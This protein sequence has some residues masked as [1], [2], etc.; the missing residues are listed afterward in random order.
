[1][2][3]PEYSPRMLRLFIEGRIVCAM[4]IDGLSRK[5]ARQAALRRIGKAAGLPARH[6]EIAH[7][8]SMFGAKNRTRVWAA[9]GIHP[10]DHGI[11]LTD[12]GG[13]VVTGHG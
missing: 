8:G 5:K 4:L 6:V 9:L 13:Q 2:T 3:V 7:M 11:M 12:N 10:V 1:M